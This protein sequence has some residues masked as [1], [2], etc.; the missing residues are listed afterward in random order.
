M[1]LCHVVQVC[2][3]QRE[4]NRACAR[5]I[6][7]VVLTMTPLAG[8]VRC[9]IRLATGLGSRVFVLAVRMP[10]AVMCCECCTQAGWCCIGKWS[11]EAS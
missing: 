10:D 11:G 5:V 8:E 7:G 2:W 3:G 6:V 9:T 1:I 4:S